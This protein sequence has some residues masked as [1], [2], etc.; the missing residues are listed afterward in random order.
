MTQVFLILVTL[1]LVIINGQN[2]SSIWIVDE[3]QIINGIVQ[4]DKTYSHYSLIVTPDNYDGISMMSIRVIQ[5]QFNSDP[6][7]FIS[8]VSMNSFTQYSLTNS[9][10]PH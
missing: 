4:N 3:G 1:N 10:T 9:L 6:D 5:E 2:I 8:L 7:I